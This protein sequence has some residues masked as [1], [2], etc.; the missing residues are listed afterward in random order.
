M[1]CAKDIMTTAVITFPPDLEINQ[2]AKS[3]LEKRINGAPVVNSDGRLI[4]ILCQSD[5]IATQKKLSLPSLFTLLDGFFP[6]SSL[7]SMEKE[8]QKIAAITV[9]KAMSANP[10]TVAPETPI[11][12]IATLMVEKGFHTLPV[13]D[14]GQLVGVVGKE[15]ILKTLCQG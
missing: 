8:V 7:K 3:L 6:L 5:L 11:E 10:V 9:D 2:A 14:K 12:E 1:L 15:D 13:V 4:G